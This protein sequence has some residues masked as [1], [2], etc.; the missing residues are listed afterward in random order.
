MRNE[1]SAPFFAPDL[2]PFFPFYSFPYPLRRQRRGRRRRSLLRPL[3]RSTATLRRRCGRD[4]GVGIQFAP[5]LDSPQGNPRV[6]TLATAGFTY[7]NIPFLLGRAYGNW[8]SEIVAVNLHI[9][10]YFCLCCK[11]LILCSL[12]FFKSVVQNCEIFRIIKC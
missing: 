8:T 9:R 6:N 1:A 10:N 3:S 2:L 12:N 4:D 7:V 5:R 11:F